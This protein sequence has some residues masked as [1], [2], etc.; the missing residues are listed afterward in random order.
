M[1][2][3]EIRWS[4]F[5]H[6]INDL[7]YLYPCHKHTFPFKEVDWDCTWSRV[8]QAAILG[9]FIRLAAMH[10][11]LAYSMQSKTC[12]ACHT[13]LRPRPRAVLTGFITGLTHLLMNTIHTQ[14]LSCWTIVLNYNA[15]TKT[16]YSTRAALQYDNYQSSSL[17][18]CLPFS[19]VLSYT[20]LQ[21]PY[22]SW[23]SGFC[24]V[25]LVTFLFCNPS[26]CIQSIHN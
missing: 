10:A 12:V 18:V 20:L 25:L 7:V 22:N 4:T 19:S 14:A 1:L 21:H 13:A 3:L 11:V 2:D 16:L 5:I 17:S 24:F 6:L 15:L 8:T 23:F 26:L 9:R